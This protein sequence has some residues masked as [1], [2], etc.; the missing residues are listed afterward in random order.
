M[1]FVVLMGLKVKL[2]LKMKKKT[3]VGAVY[4]GL[5]LTRIWGRLGSVL[6]DPVSQLMTMRGVRDVFLSP[7]SPHVRP[8][9]VLPAGVYS[10]SPFFSFLFFLSSG[11]VYGFL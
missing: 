8:V 9:A 10:F 1:Y 6:F 7:A 2:K 3:K 5:F 4:I 11:Q